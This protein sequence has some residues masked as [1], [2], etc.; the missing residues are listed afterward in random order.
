MS[1][2][3]GGIGSANG[4][5]QHQNLCRCFSIAEIQLATNNFNDALVVGKGGFGKVYKGFIN[6][7]ATSVA[8]KR[9]NAESR[10]GADEFWMEIKTLSKLRHTHLVSLLGYCDDDEEMIL[11]YEYMYHGT[12]ADH[13]HKV[14]GNYLFHLNWEQRLKICLG[15]ACGL[16]FLHTN[17]KQ[18]IIHR[19]VKSTNILLD[20]NWVAK[21]S[22]FGLSKV[23]TTSTINTQSH[24]S[25]NVKGTFGYLDP[26]Y[27]LTR[28]L[29]KKS[30]V[31]AFGVVLFEVLC[32]RPAVD[33]RLEEEQ[34]SLAFWAQECIKNA[35]IDQIVDPSLRAEIS[36]RSLKVFI[37]IADRCLHNNSKRRPTMAQ[38][39][40]SLD[41]ALD[42]Q[43]KTGQC[44][45]II[46]KVFKRVAL[47]LL[48]GIGPEWWTRMT[49]NSG[50]GLFPALRGDA[51]EDNSIRLCHQ[52]V[53]HL[54]GYFN[55]THQLIYTTEKMI[56]NSLSYHLYETEND[57]PPWEKRL[58]ICIGVARGLRY[59]HTGSKM[60]IVH[61]DLQPSNILLDK[62][63][64]PKISGFEFSVVMNDNE[65]L[66][67]HH[68]ELIPGAFAYLDPEYL[69]SGKLTPKS[70]IY[71]FGVILLELLCGRNPTVFSTKWCQGRL[72]CGL[73]FDIKEET[74]HQN[75]DPFLAGKIMPACFLE[76][77][78]VTR[79]CLSEQQKERP[80]IDE[81]LRSLE[82]MLF[83]QQT[84]DK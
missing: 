17:T 2:L 18:N 80:S 16:D 6:Q 44:K 69:R 29:S 82:Y 62:N 52:N 45:G 50:N 60:T 1:T 67:L 9:L 48:K 51:H 61:R 22:D 26:E 30:D 7:G 11:V 58:E 3:N 76:F 83:L 4:G 13:L 34:H 21:I 10:Q 36:P 49:S 12:L 56:N 53:V 72:V 55:E 31:Y 8:I 71:S 77:V 81:V 24:I 70:D 84:L 37:E 35:M 25:T 28:R 64:V 20:D 19:D 54:I 63:W 57:P 46:T 68:S 75:I 42:L 65:Y 78:S 74:V 43:L 5:I 39:V 15:A 33:T 27:F 79:R 23:G 47:D 40:K 14:K 32:G 41:L 59:L 66:Y 73:K 38:V